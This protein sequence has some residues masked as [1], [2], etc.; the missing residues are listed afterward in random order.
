MNKTRRKKI[1]DQMEIIMLTRTEIEAIMGDEEEYRD[2]TPENLQSSSNWDASDVACDHM[3]EA[4]DSLEDLL[5]NL[6]SAI[7]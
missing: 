6:E 2:K 3:Q 1:S 7:E 4:L 5:S